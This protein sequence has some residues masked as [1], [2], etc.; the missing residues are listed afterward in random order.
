MI[1]QFRQYIE[2][3]EDTTK[4]NIMNYLIFLYFQIKGINMFILHKQKNDPFKNFSL[5]PLNNFF[6]IPDC[7][8]QRIIRFMTKTQIQRMEKIW[9]GHSSSTITF[10]LATIGD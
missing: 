6:P 1:I 10:F 3:K 2:T 5:K 7:I 8:C 9:C 4:K